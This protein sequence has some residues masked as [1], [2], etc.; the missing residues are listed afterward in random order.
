MSPARDFGDN[1][2]QS[3]DHDPD[4]TDHPT[5]K[6][7]HDMTTPDPIDPDQTGP[8]RAIEAP[9]PSSDPRDIDAPTAGQLYQMFPDAFPTNSPE[10][11]NRHL[12]AVPDSGDV[13]TLPAE[14]FGDDDDPLIATAL[15]WRAVITFWWRPT[16]TAVVFVVVAVVAFFAAGT[17]VGVAWCV[18]GIAKTAHTVWHVHGRP[19]LRQFARA[20]RGGNW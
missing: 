1:D 2:D 10:R 16:A 8:E 7:A 19:S 12:A 20:R 9:K 14:P 17:A 11:R 18:L 5:D 3:G 13:A 6:E 4:N 15:R